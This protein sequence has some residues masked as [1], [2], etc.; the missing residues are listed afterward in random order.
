M[1]YGV[2]VS[3]ESAR[4]QT[5][6]D[7]VR[8]CVDE[9]RSAAQ[10]SDHFF[11]GV[12]GQVGLLFDQ[13]VQQHQQRCD[14]AA[15]A[16]GQL[17]EKV[18]QLE[19][20]E[21]RLEAEQKRLAAEGPGEAAA[22]PGLE[23]L[24]ELLDQARD[25]RQLLGQVLEASGSQDSRL[26]QIASEL[27]EARQEMLRQREAFDKAQTSGVRPEAEVEQRLEE[28]QQQCQELS[29]E[30]T[31]L[32]SELDA[33]RSR[34]AE[35]AETVE[36]QKQLMSQQSAQ[37]ADELRLQ[38]KLLERFLTHMN[39]QMAE[40]LESSPE[41]AAPAS[42]PAPESPSAAA[43]DAVLDSVMAQFEMLQKDLAR[44]RKGAKSKQ[45]SK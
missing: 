41:P 36:Q 5:A 26:T 1:R 10:E 17:Q 18:R 15:A 7:G 11:D 27:A 28:L 33:V 31:V 20:R 14:E 25:E 44:R 19:Q 30:R 37:W 16:E 23:E 45:T 22:L 21:S 38:R 35:M 9:V 4:T 32:E 39:E 40:A 42:A 2:N 24:H 43:D 29:Q 12:F 34:A 6:W 3:S 8:R 13:M